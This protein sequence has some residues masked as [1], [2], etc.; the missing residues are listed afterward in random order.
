MTTETVINKTLKTIRQDKGWT[1]Q[2]VADMI[3]ISITS[4]NLIE[5][6]RKIGRIDTWKKLQLLFNINDID[7]WNLIKNKR[8]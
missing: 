2:E 6:G 8:G 7:M 1:Q 5:Q 3:G 4:Y